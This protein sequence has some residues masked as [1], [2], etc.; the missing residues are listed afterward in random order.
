M[1]ACARG[2]LNVIAILAHWNPDSV[3]VAN[4]ANWRPAALL[5]H[6]GHHEIV[7]LFQQ[8][9]ST[10]EM[11]ALE[12]LSVDQQQQQWQQQLS[13]S[14]DFESCGEIVEF[15]EP[16]S[17]ELIFSPLCPGSLP[18]VSE[19]KTKFRTFRKPSKDGRGD[20]PLPS[21]QS[22]SRAGENGTDMCS[23]VLTKCSS[24]RRRL[25]L[26][27][28][29]SV[30]I[31]PDFPQFHN[32][33]TKLS[34]TGTHSGREDGGGGGDAAEARC[35]MVATTTE[36]V[37]CTIR[38]R[39]SSSDPHLANLVQLSH[40][41]AGGGDPMISRIDRDLNSPVLFLEASSCFSED[42]GLSLEDLQR[43]TVAME[44]GL[45]CTKHRLSS[46]LLC[47]EYCA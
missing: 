31:L 36:H 1:W 41:S 30:D 32:E 27:K 7:E 29:T 46:F 14:Q 22:A 44:M 8:I 12:E 33:L 18:P 10:S 23:S 19:A 17:C 21:A 38:L 35:H 45:Y 5:N 34:R 16:S 6:F 47:C 37:S 11:T 4:K 39:T 25:R 43:E 20:S 24:T 2:H 13:S 40:P 42:K 28:R 26:M 15:C 3:H 9:D